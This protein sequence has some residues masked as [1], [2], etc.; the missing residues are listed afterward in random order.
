MRILLSLSP[1]FCGRKV[2]YRF[3]AMHRLL[4]NRAPA[5]RTPKG[6]CP[7]TAQVPGP[8]KTSAGVTLESSHV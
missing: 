8:S 2:L 4:T 5:A 3:S 1:E 6:F 7:E